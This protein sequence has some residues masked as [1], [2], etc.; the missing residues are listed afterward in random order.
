MDSLVEI[1]VENIRITI[2]KTSEKIRK[3][4]SFYK[5]SVYKF[6]FQ[7]LFLHF[8]TTLPTKPDNLLLSYFIHYS[9]YPTTITTK[10]NK[11]V[12]ERILK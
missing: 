4:F 2:S 5:K 11:I 12:K 6:F 3:T 7:P 1:I 10:Y 9:T 8:S